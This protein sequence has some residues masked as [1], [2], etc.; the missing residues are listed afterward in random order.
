MSVRRLHLSEAGT[1]LISADL[2]SEIVSCVSPA[3]SLTYNLMQ[4]K[5]F[6]NTLCDFFTHLL[7]LF[8]LAYLNFVRRGSYDVS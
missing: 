3:N 4:V 2:P 1:R 8:S 6:F 7:Q 5:F